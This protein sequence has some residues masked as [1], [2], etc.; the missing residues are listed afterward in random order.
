MTQLVPG[1]QGQLQARHQR[2]S[3]AQL[4]GLSV[5]A[6]LRLFIGAQAPLKLRRAVPAGVALLVLALVIA[7]RT[8]ATR[9]S[10]A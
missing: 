2:A 3:V 10:L 1:S 6:D 7:A 4:V 9:K 8:L 5:Y